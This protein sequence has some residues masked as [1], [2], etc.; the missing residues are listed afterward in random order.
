M[1]SDN[2]RTSCA[3]YIWCAF[4]Q[5]WIWF[6]YGAQEC[7]AQTLQLQFSP[8]TIIPSILGRMQPAPWTRSIFGLRLNTNDHNHLFVIRWWNI[9]AIVDSCKAVIHNNNN[10]VSSEIAKRTR[11]SMVY[12]IFFRFSLAKSWRRMNCVLFTS[13]FYYCTYY[14]S[15]MYWCGR[16]FVTFRKRED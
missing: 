3:I 16:Y 11:R 7:N 12:L 10:N 14:M 2:S 6:Q 8:S 9:V 15:Y 1:N 5:I 13:R 4:D